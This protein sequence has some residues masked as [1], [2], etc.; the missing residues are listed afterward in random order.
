M[1]YRGDWKTLVCNSLT[2]VS[3]FPLW[4]PSWPQRALVLE[5]LER[6]II[7][8]CWEVPCF[9]YLLTFWNTLEN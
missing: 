4:F 6:T 3:S 5:L 8:G 2:P 1:W 7:L 9:F